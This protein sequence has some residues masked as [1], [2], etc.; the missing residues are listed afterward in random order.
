MAF[1]N[2]GNQHINQVHIPI[3]I[4]E[5]QHH[6]F[7]VPKI[8]TEHMQ[9]E[10]LKMNSDDGLSPQTVQLRVDQN[11][12]DPAK[13]ADTGDNTNRTLNLTRDNDIIQINELVKQ[14]KN[15]ER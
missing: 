11:A 9:G 10:Q 5:S 6:R 12:T 1:R 13:V 7:V 8:Q 3:N 15:N 4:A 14:Q 2:R